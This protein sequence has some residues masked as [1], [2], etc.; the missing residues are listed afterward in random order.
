MT[1]FLFISLWPLLQAQSPLTPCCATASA[2]CSCW[3]DA[4]NCGQVAFRTQTCCMHGGA[5][6]ENCWVGTRTFQKCCSELMG[7]WRG[8]KFTLTVE[9]ILDMQRQ[10][11][12]N[13]SGKLG[14]GT[15]K[16]VAYFFG[17]V[18]EKLHFRRA[19]EVGVFRGEFGAALLKSAPSLTHYF[20]VD[21][22]TQQANS[23]DDWN[24]NN[25]LQQEN[26]HVAIRTLRAAAGEKVHIMQLQS[27]NASR[28]FFDE[29]LDFVFLDA[30]HDYCSVLTDLRVWWP[31]VRPGGMIA[32]DDYHRAQGSI[33]AESWE[34]CP[35]GRKHYGGVLQ[36][37]DDFF[38]K[39]FGQQSK[40]WAL[41]HVLTFPLRGRMVEEMYELAEARNP[42]WFVQKPVAM[43]RSDAA[44]FRTQSSP[45]TFDESVN[46][47]FWAA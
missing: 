46:R 33:T 17:S 10:M 22:W 15:T 8:S 2:A 11:V 43:S 36:A 37:V 1:Y 19:V 39:Q 5:T 18:M 6:S 26:Q 9:S 20:G 34:V 14:F 12:K 13:N 45:T 7:R 28:A 24:I 30:R 47:F 35:T 32:G 38:A 41:S 4:D 42:C 16:D 27:V 23:A 21:P 40:E 3:N 44:E 29:S 25:D 31:K